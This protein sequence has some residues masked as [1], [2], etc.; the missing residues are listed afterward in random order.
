MVRPVPRMAPEFEAAARELEPTVR[1]AKV[2]A[3]GFPE[4]AAGFSIRSIPT[5]ILFSREREIKRESGAV[6]RSAIV[7]LVPRHR[8]YDSLAAFG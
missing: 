1:L 7:A 6:G 5:M 4:I 3:E 8:D 2:D